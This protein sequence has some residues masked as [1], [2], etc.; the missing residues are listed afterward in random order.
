MERESRWKGKGEGEE[1]LRGRGWEE[2]REQDGGR[3]WGKRAMV[4]VGEE[5]G[6]GGGSRDEGE[7]GGERGE[8]QQEVV[9]M[10]RVGGG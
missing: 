10:W 2:E 6:G 4:K 1:G 3:K 7:G 5:E 8:E 9:S